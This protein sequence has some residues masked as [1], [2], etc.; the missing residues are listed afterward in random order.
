M[1]ITPGEAGI[2][3]RYFNKYKTTP[4]ES[5]MVIILVLDRI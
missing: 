3:I 5:G 2:A 4:V 1:K